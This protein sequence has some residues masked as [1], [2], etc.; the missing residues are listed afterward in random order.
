MN[1]SNISDRRIKVSPR[2]PETGNPVSSFSF[3][4]KLPLHLDVEEFSW[5]SPLEVFKNLS[6]KDPLIFLDAASFSG[7]LT[8]SIIAW[9]PYLWVEGK[10][11]SVNVKK[12]SS[13]RWERI[14]TE[15]PF[16]TLQEK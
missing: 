6:S 5:R 11:D 12:D 8:R 4:K 13:R 3:L 16:D 10:K 14:K 1:T 15:K 9:D 7:E 2:V